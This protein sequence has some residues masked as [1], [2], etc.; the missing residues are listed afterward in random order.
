MT[1]QATPIID[2]NGKRT[3]VHKKSATYSTSKSDALR[4]PPPASSPSKGS[5]G[6]LVNKAARSIESAGD[7]V[8]AGM[9]SLISGVL[10]DEDDVFA[11]DR[12]ER[13]YRKAERER[14]RAL[15]TR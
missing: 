14:E 9:E 5:I 1:T 6:I 7:A 3:T 15:L 11:E 10:G 8:D 2:K 13:E 4:L 12:I